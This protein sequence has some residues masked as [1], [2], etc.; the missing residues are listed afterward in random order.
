LK[1]GELATVKNKKMS[2]QSVNKQRYTA[3][4][5]NKLYFEH[6]PL[7]DLST[8]LK[9]TYGLT[10]MFSDP[11]LETRELSG[12]I[13]AASV[14]EILFAMGETLDLKVE[15]EGQLVRISSKHH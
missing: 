1:P 3:W 6:T 11:A 9:D 13:S 7:R 14:D 8:L 5:E 10:V 4:V 12:E 15:K 2:T